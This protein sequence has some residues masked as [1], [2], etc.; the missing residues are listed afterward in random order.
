[1][2]VDKVILRSFLST[3]AAIAILFTFMLSALVIVYP[4]TMMEI[5][6][7]LGMETPSIWFA[8]ESYKRTDDVGYIAYATEV[9][10]GEGK[11][12]KVEE[13]G[14]RLIADKGFG[15]YCE[16]KNT[17][18][19]EEVTSDYEDYVYGQ[20]CIALYEQGKHDEAV[21]RAF[22]LTGTA[23]PKNNAVTAVIVK[24]KKASD[25][26]TLGKIRV[27]MEQLQS[28]LPEGDKE[29]FEGVFGLVKEG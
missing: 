14:E 15:T 13:C 6:Y 29:Y 8:E 4:Q 7:K 19:G 26:V 9:A 16:E 23:F 11:Y 18:L 2:G 22:A 27:K 24:A 20:I 21:E 12:E 25:T 3:L 10:I 1:M 28:K 5:T 17:A